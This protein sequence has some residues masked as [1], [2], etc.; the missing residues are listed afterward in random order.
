MA[1]KM[2]QIGVRIPQ[3]HA[4][5]IASLEIEGAK[6]PSDK[7]RAIIA[8]AHRRESGS[9]DYQ[10]SLV[11]VAELL[12][13]VRNRIRESEMML[14][15]HSE[16]VGRTLDWLSE[17]LAFCV[18]SR[19]ALAK[20]DTPENLERFEAQLADRLFRQIESTLQLGVTERSPCYNPKII[21]KKVTPV[22][23]LASI[24]ASTRPVN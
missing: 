7:L 15:Q 20:A 18:A 5:F 12:T 3:E 2:V 16:L 19:Q 11:S 9:H 22:L 24:I 14:E 6:T 1:S 4:D 23:D 8:Q 17:M 21:A 10:A 13:P